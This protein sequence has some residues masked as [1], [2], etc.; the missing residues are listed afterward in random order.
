[1]DRISPNAAAR[2]VQPVATLD[3][4]GF[5]RRVGKEHWGR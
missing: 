3:S 4:C 5:S 2:I 1:M